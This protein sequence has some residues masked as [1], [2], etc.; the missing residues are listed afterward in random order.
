MQ[1]HSTTAF[2]LLDHVMQEHFVLV[3]GEACLVFKGGKRQQ[4]LLMFTRVLSTERSRGRY[5]TA[6]RAGSAVEHQCKEV[7]N[8]L[9]YF[10]LDTRSKALG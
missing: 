7:W 1:Q 6:R 3:C 8:H 5:Q 9:D 10:V 2:V 4:H